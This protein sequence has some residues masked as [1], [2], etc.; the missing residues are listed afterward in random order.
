LRLGRIDNPGHQ[1]DR[2]AGD[3]AVVLT[4]HQRQPVGRGIWNYP[5]AD[6][7]RGGGK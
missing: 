3:I 1:I 2:Q 4:A 6:D 7:A 5:G